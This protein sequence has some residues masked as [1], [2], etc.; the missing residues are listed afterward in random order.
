MFGKIGLVAVVCFVC[1][2]AEAPLRNNHFRS[3]RLRQASPSQHF[4][5]QQAGGPYAPT[6]SQPN[7]P[8]NL[9]NPSIN[10]R[11]GPPP[12]PSSHYG[13]PSNNGDSN[14]SI[15]SDLTSNETTDNPDS[16]N[17]AGSGQ[18]G[19][20]QSGRFEKLRKAPGGSHGKQRQ[21][22]FQRLQSQPSLLSQAQFL[23]PV[24][25]QAPAFHHHQVQ[26]PFLTSVGQPLLPQAELL[27]RLELQPIQQEGSYFIQLPSGTIQRVNYVAQPSHVDSS[28]SARLQFRPIVEAQAT[29]VAEQPQIYVN[30]LVQAYTNAANQ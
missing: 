30:T 20:F 2:A 21:Q 5:R 29:A 28:V 17:V 23:Q 16:E 9:P 13:P 6:G 27:Q 14:V 24:Q 10:T 11:Y 3:Q 25:V 4:A 18:S 22:K 1:I 15:E 7:V 26:Q 19:R 8:F 12:A